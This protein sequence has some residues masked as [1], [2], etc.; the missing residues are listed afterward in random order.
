VKQEDGEFKAS[1]GYILRP[2]LKREQEKELKSTSGQDGLGRDQD[3]DSRPAQEKI[4]KTHRGTNKL[5]VAVQACHPSC[6][7]GIRCRRIKV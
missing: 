4:S 2:R 3:F 7:V 6:T 5:S 1:L